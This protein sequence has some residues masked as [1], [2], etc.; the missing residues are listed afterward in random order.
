[1]TG[2]SFGDISPALGTMRAMTGR[3]AVVFGAEGFIGGY[4]LRSLLARGIAPLAATLRTVPP[5]DRVPGARYLGPCD[6]T[7]AGRVDRVLRAAE[8][9]FVY[10]LAAISLP[11]VSWKEPGRTLTVNVQGTLNVLESVRRL[12]GDPR[13]FVACSSAEYGHGHRPGTPTRETAPLLP[14]HAYGVSKVAQ[15]L[16]SYQYFANYGVRTIRG[17]IF[18]TI[19]PGKTGEVTSDIAR[20]IVAIEQGRRPSVVRVGNVRPLRDFTDVRDMVGGIRSITERGRPGE[21]YNLASGRAVSVR[22]VLE[23][24]LSLATTKVRWAVDRA[25]LRP[26]DEPYIVGNPARVRRATGWS[27]RYPLDRTLADILAWFRQTP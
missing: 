1:M 16:L 22:T 23:R 6:V 13:V 20:Q 12:R 26:T 19:G 9:E 21:A 18:N 14:L 15:D 24:L 4:L 27:A 10:H 2:L 25:R 8:P 3:S 7:D 17:R 5:T 11:T